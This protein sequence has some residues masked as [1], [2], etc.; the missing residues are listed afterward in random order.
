MTWI[1]VAW[2]LNCDHKV[3]SAHMDSVRRLHAGRVQ[4]CPFFTP[5]R[6]TASRQRGARLING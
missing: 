2:A 3:S 4:I 5:G 1:L 6:P